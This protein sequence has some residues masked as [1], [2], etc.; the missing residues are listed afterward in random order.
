[1]TTSGLHYERSIKDSKSLMK[2]AVGQE[3]ADLVVINARLLN[4]YSGELLDRHS[5]GINGEWIAYVGEDPG[6][7]IGPQTEVI[8]AGGQTVIPGLIE[9]HTHLL[10]YFTPYEFLKHAMKGGTTTVITETMEA[11]PVGG[12]EGITDFL[13]SIDEQP[14]K[15][16]A[17]ATTM[18]SISKDLRGDSMEAIQKLLGRR[19][20]IGLGETYWQS[21][22]QEPDRLLPIFY[23]T[24]RSGKVL[25]GHSAGAKGKKLMAY[26]ASGVSSCHESITAEEAL[27]KLRLGLCVMIREGS[28]RRDLE[29][30]SRIKDF[31]VDFRRLILVSDGL[32]PKDLLKKGGMEFIV[33]KAIHCGFDPISAIQMATLNV[34]E[35]FSLDGLMGGIAPG[36]FADVVIIP[37]PNTIDAQY[38]IS[39]G[40]L[41]AKNGNLLVPPR[42]HTFS[43]ESLNSIHLPK[44]IDPSDFSIRVQNDAKQAEVR[45]IELVTGLVTKEANITLPVIRNE[46]RLDVSRDILKVAAIDRTHCPGKMFVGFV[47]GFCMKKGAFATSGAWDTSDIIVVGA[48]DADMAHAVNRINDIQGGAVIS[49]NGEIIAEL[50][51]PILGILSDLPLETVA[52]KMAEINKTAS[53]FGVPFDDPLT[54]LAVLT[55]AA[56]PYLRICEEGLV[57]LRKDRT[58]GIFRS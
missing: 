1:M 6:N 58:L 15:I 50:P 21:V 42:K 19:D 35:H 37:D 49:D 44:K 11:F 24:L 43:P 30:I 45:I 41:I 33:Q 12:Y 34:A 51:L 20:I 16:F 31:G 29:A 13:S 9:G 22:L 3:R 57:D 52:R 7:T 10:W 27:E 26:I 25:E 5:I 40:R 46:I 53:A 28:V 48:N 38:V 54:T 18:P 2:V 39:R 14:I 17:T 23:E 55:T 47:K 32:E 8:D 36:R 56:I 4:V